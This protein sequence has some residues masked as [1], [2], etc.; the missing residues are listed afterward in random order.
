VKNISFKGALVQGMLRA[1]RPGEVVH[2]QFGEGQ[3]QFRVVWAGR[4]GTPAEGEL[5][6]EGLPAEPSIWDLDLVQCAEFAGKG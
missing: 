1:V 3:A 4:K 5:G 2:V 6:I